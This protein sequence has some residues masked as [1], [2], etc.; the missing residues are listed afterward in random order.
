MTA[1][2][3]ASST[4]RANSTPQLAMIVGYGL[5]GVSA[6][7]LLAAGPR[8][9]GP[10]G[11][12]SLALAW[13]LV[14]IVGL[15]IAAPGEQTITRGIAAGAG[16]GIVLAVGR[17]MALL[18]VLCAI[19]LPLVLN[20]GPLEI[21]DG[22]LWATAF[23]AAAAAWVAL[24]C[25]RGVL[26]GRHRFAAYAMVLLVEAVGR[27][28]LVGLAFW[29]RPQAPLLLGGA[30]V[31]PLIAAA[32]LG[33]WFLRRRHEV[34]DRAIA[35]DSTLE[36]G[37]ITAVAVLI[38]VCLSTAPLWLSG[39]ST[40]AALAGAFVSATSYMRIP[41]LLAG[42]LYGPILAEAARRFAARDRVGVRNR[43]LVG[44]A[45]GVGGTT[46]ATLLLLL[47]A[48]PALL[49]LYGSGI[50]ISVGVLAWLGFG[51]VASV[52]S[53]VLT[54][55]LYGCQSAPAAAMA[56]VPPAV[57]TT[58]LLASAGGDELRISVAMAVGQVVAVASLA[59]L[60]PRAL[61]GRSERIADEPT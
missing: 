7:A 3:G 54:Q 41:L 58:V 47:A 31:L 12:T 1:P 53:N 38:Q 42:G 24:A 40:D 34:L 4:R 45:A 37:S 25:I 59:L 51:T 11:H 19:G 18:P 46:V 56:W 49:V 29:W 10:E 23:T 60:L 8:L 43:T 52:A 30:I 32:V 2:A 26:A 61:P 44:L 35:E 21:A 22:A 16:T 6:F 13:T 20:A 27:V 50:G 14:T 9:L 5:V 48:G 57:L 33:W 36:H 55:V 28:G 39:Q 17:R 15:G